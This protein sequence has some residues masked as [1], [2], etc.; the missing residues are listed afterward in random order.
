[1]QILWSVSQQM[2]VADGTPHIFNFQMI[3]LIDIQL[4]TKALS[5]ASKVSP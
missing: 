3:T 1:M 4:I 5:V 2:D